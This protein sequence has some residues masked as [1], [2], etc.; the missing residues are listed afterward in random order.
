LREIVMLKQTLIAAVVFTVGLSVSAIAAEMSVP[1]GA[2]VS[3]ASAETD[4]TTAARD[5]AGLA[6]THAAARE[7]DTAHPRIQPDSAVET[8]NDTGAHA[9]VGADSEASSKRHRSRWQSLLPGVM[10]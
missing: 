5:D 9:S 6:G 1:G 3:S 2:L 10:K 8:H 7:S 4:T